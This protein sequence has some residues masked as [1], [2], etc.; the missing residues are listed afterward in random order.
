MSIDL[1]VSYARR[2]SG[3]KAELYLD[4]FNLLNQQRTFEIDAT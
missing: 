3:G 4:L 2:L 1:E